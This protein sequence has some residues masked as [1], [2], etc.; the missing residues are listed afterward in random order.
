M[1]ATARGTQ[2]RTAIVTAAAELFAQRGFPAV[3]MDEIGAS[4]G[5]TGPAIYRHFN[6]K[7]SVLAA[8]IDRIIDAVDLPTTGADSPTLS[9]S[10]TSLAARIDHYAAGVAQRRGLMA[11]F[12]REMHHLPDEHA[13]LLK[14]RQRE[15]VAQWRGQLAAAHPNWDAEKVRTSIHAVFGMLNAVGTFTSALSD[16]ELAAQLGA[17]AHAALELP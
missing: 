9:G 8:V 15:M 7:A 1:T 11:V 5:V 4:A 10:A 14:Q 17:L 16:D 3:G 12:V 13:A 6:S 2:R